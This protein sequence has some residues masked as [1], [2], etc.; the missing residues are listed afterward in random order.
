MMTHNAYPLCKEL[1]QH[2]SRLPA[3]IAVAESCTGGGLAYHLTS[4]PGASRWFERGFV[5][6]T[7]AAKQDCLSVP[8]KTIEQHGQVSAETA[9][10]M[11]MGVL[12]HSMADIALSITGIAGPTGGSAQKPVGTVYF[13]LALRQPHT[14]EWRHACFD[15]GRQ[16]VRDEAIYFALDWLLTTLRGRA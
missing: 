16:H 7:A 8:V 6:Y 9:C 14:V 4:V 5:T 1:G 3:Q 2:L 11:A 10:A 12:Q 15:S 13:G